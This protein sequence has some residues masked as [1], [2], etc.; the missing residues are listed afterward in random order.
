MNPVGGDDAEARAE[1]AWR[2]YILQ[3]AENE[4]DP[5]VFD[6]GAAPAFGRIS[7]AVQ[8]T[9]RTPRRRVAD[10]L[11]ASVAAARRLPLYTTNPDDFADLDGLVDVV[12][13][14]R[15]DTRRG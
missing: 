14:P 13:V 1:R 4:F 2:T 10:L 7:A 5:I 15:P 12:Q 9:G 8:D 6:A 11:I 3:R